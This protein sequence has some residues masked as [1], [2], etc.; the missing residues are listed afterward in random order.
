MGS[1]GT[2]LPTPLCSVP[3]WCRGGVTRWAGWLPCAH[4]GVLQ[5]PWP[6]AERPRALLASRLLAPPPGDAGSVAKP[7]PLR[8]FRGEAV[9]ERYLRWSWGRGAAPQVLVC[10]GQAAQG[11]QGSLAQ[12][13]LLQC[14]QSHRRSSPALGWAEGPGRGAAAP[15]RPLGGGWAALR[16]GARD[17]A[18]GTQ[19]RSHWAA[20]LCLPPGRPFLVPHGL[21]D[22]VG[23]KRKRKGPRKLQDFMKWF[24]AA[25][26]YRGCRIPPRIPP[27]SGQSRGRA[28][29]CRQTPSPLPWALQSWPAPLGSG[30]GPAAGAPAPGLAG[31]APATP[32]HFLSGMHIA[33][34]GPGPP[35]PGLSLNHGAAEKGAS[36]LREKEPAR[37]ARLGRALHGTRLQQAQSARPAAAP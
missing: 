27:L 25:C 24:S 12:P 2:S 15:A 21:D 5:G 28:P 7:R 35:H 37:A 20:D 26:E 8:R 13:L 23:G 22:V 16:A 32:S 19:C 4:P 31:A 29:L 1:P 9:Q 10:P 30:F 3:R 18:R 11:R 34:V 33:F 6:G 14:P 36:D 17:S